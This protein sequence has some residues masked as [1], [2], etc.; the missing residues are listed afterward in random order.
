M[1]TFK[2]DLEAARRE[3]IPVMALR[4]RHDDPD[5]MDDIV[6][7]NPAMFRAESRST[8][9]QNQAQNASSS[10]SPRSRPSGRTGIR[11]AARQLREK[12][13]RHNRNPNVAHHP[14]ALLQLHQA[15]PA[16]RNAERH[17]HTRRAPTPPQTRRGHPAQPHQHHQAT[18]ETP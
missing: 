8:S 15:R 17:E 16:P 7:Q 4:P 5:L 1:S 6:V 2:R 18:E 12:P 13:R 10:A 3:R 9:P 11:C 14:H